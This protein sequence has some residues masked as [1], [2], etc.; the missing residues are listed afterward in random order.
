MLLKLSIFY[1]IIPNIYWNNNQKVTFILTLLVIFDNLGSLTCL[2][3][4]IEL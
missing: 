4:I 1:F 3:N 2:S